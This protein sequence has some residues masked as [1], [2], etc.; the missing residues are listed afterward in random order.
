MHHLEYRQTRAPT[1]YGKI[2][3]WL[4]NGV[5]LLAVFNML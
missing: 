4:G 1:K 5:L 2:H 3:V